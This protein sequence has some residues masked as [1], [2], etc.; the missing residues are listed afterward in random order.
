MGEIFSALRGDFVCVEGI[1]G[2]SSTK[3][4]GEIF[5]T[6]GEILLGRFIS[7]ILFHTF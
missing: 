4:G 1:F 7:G 2:G 6:T 5:S 3:I